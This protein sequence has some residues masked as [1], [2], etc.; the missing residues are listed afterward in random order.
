MGRKNARRRGD[1]H[2]E[3]LLMDYRCPLGAIQPKQMDTEAV[4]NDAWHNDGFLVVHINDP[5]LNW[6]EQ[7]IIRQIGDRLFGKKGKR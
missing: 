4:K 5:K 1:C 6:M 7:Q 3:I 2:A